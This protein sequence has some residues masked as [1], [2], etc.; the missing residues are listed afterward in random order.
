MT[1]RAVRILKEADLIAAE[2]TRHTG[3]LLHHFQ[4]ETPQISYHTHNTQRRIPDLIAQLQ[5]GKTI[6]LVSDAG[7]PGISDPGYELVCACTAAGIVVS[8]IPGPSAVVS[9]IAASGLPT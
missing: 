9:A 4:I 6:A 1:F 8:P 2:D 5:A 7:M 3:K